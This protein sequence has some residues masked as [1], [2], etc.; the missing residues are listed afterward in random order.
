MGQQATER[1]VN[2]TDELAPRGR[3]IMMVLL[4]L[5]QFMAIL[6]ISVV[7]IALPVIGISLHLSR[8]TLTWVLTGYTV[9]FG[10]LLVLGG[11]LADAVG[12]KVMFMTGLLLFIVASL[13]SGL[14]GSGGMLLAGRTLQGLGA[15]LLSP[16]ALSILTTEFSG[17]DRDRALGI[18]GAIS[19]GGAAVGFVVGGALTSGPG[20]EWAFF[21]N[22][23]VGLI[24]LALGLVMIPRRSR[25]AGQGADV[26][27]AVTATGA[28]ALVIFG[29]IR[30]GDKGWGSV[31][32]LLPIAIGVVLAAA[33]VLIERRVSKPL[34]PLAL[35]RRPPL[36]GSIAIFG[37]ATA[38]LLGAYFIA[39][40]YLQQAERYSPIHTGLIFLP[41]AIAT[42]I[43]A[44]FASHHMG[45]LGPRP[46]TSV[47]M[48]L[49]TLGLG[50]M[51][52]F[53]VGGNTYGELLPGFMVT[54]AGVGMSFV[55]AL[56]SGLSAVDAER[57]GV[58]SG[59]LNTG[60]E[61]G[62]SLGIAIFSTVAASSISAGMHVVLSGYRDALL[63]A[64]AGSILLALLAVGLMPKGAIKR[65]DGPLLIH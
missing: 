12:R 18:W 34:V 6:D 31:S 65:T 25:I 39:S 1:P 30:A 29:L 46:L 23:P 62:A 17:K 55:S 40:V 19:A 36:P 9:M 54:G 49:S 64:A 10:G 58:A 7:N 50:T 59:I 16:S 28:V 52:W 48:I 24:V 27:G 13:V 43:G 26:P 51:A 15:A 61:L 14:A 37:T 33:F 47:G 45:K 60:H 42:G 44:H 4:C 57:A 22:L 2:A 35:V 21:I 63:V 8:E 11:R 5:A 32:A 3:W 53:G 38:I 20:W 41:V 56:T